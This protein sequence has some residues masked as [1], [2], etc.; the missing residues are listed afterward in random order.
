MKKINLRNW[1]MH[2]LSEAQSIFHSEQ[3]VMYDERYIRYQE[4]VGRVQKITSEGIIYINPIELKLVK[5]K[6]HLEK[7]WWFRGW[8]KYDPTKIEKIEEDLLKFMPSFE[9]HYKDYNFYD[10]QHSLIWKG[11]GLSKL[12]NLRPIKLDENDL[13]KLTYGF[14]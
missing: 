12:W 7:F 9:S 10:S 4:K 11:E 5:N 13:V 2:R 1:K 14:V 8:S 6:R 3:I